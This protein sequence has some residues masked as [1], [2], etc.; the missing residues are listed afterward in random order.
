MI[1]ARFEAG[2]FPVS[3]WALYEYQEGN[4][5]TTIQVPTEDIA[6]GDAV[7]ISD[8]VGN[9]W[10][11]TVKE[12]LPRGAQAKLH[13]CGGK[14]ALHIS[15]TPRW[16]GE[17]VSARSVM[18]DLCGDVGETSES[19]DSWPTVGRWR[20]RG[21]SLAVEVGI[22]AKHTT[23]VWRVT[24][25]G[26]V[27]L[28]VASGVID[29]PGVFTEVQCNARVYASDALTPCAGHTIDDR[30]ISTALHAG[31]SGEDMTVTLWEAQQA[32]TRVSGTIG[33]TVQGYTNG[34]IDVLTDDGVRLTGV[35]LW[36]SPGYVPEPTDGT[37][38]IVLDLNDDPRMTI[39]L[40]GID[41]DVERV[42][43]AG[44]SNGPALWSGA[45][46]AFNVTAL[47]P[48]TSVVTLVPPTGPNVKVH[49]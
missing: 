39:A 15:T 38:V 22:L 28:S 23:G 36:A 8:D 7:M 25:G 13:I 30:I 17:P 18:Q 6:R 11:G 5:N 46:I 14:N 12:V 29:P 48:N 31:G 3:D 27:S 24:P 2:Q 44:G 4:W 16:Y 34:R 19:L 41:G 1:T 47:G 43:I 9:E 49:I 26:L 42:D 21:G 32:H 35:P 33:A 45:T 40:S 10:H 20:S 37:R